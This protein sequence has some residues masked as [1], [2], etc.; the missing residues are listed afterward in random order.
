M[1]GDKGKNYRNERDRIK[2]TIRV[3]LKIFN[4]IFIQFKNKYVFGIINII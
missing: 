1:F 3:I 2:N 4:G